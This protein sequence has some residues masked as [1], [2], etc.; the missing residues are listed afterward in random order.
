MYWKAAA[1]ASGS[2]TLIF[3]PCLPLNVQ[4]T[5]HISNIYLISAVTYEFPHCKGETIALPKQNAR[6][7]VHCNP[8]WKSYQTGSQWTT[9]GIIRLFLRFTVF[10]RLF[11]SA[12]PG[13]SS[14]LRLE[15]FPITF[16]SHC[17]TRYYINVNPDSRYIIRALTLFPNVF[18]NFQSPHT[19]ALRF[20][21]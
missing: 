17:L 13:V 5:C 19:V 16:S 14:C 20:Y 12:F 18:N 15:G 4:T 11:F 1:N 21:S 9:S 3:A 10:P 7:P 6:N 8:R 2:V